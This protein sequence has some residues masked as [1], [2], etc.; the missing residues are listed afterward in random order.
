[1]ED[2]NKN[3]KLDLENLKENKIALEKEFQDYQRKGKTIICEKCKVNEN[4]VIDLEKTLASFSKSKSDLNS[5]LNYQRS[6]SSKFGLGYVE[7]KKV[8]TPHKTIFVKSKEVPK[9]SFVKNKVEPKKN[10]FQ[11][12]NKFKSNFS[13][14][15]TPHGNTC[16]YCSKY[17]HTANKCYI[18]NIGVPKGKFIWVPKGKST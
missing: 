14:P 18:K 13:T 2:E 8:D 3:L 4:K 10:L 7:N 1:M 17:G 12:Q 9:M 5:L 6:C 11:K 15:H 16:F